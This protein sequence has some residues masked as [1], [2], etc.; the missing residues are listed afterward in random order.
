MHAALW[1][2]QRLPGLT[3]QLEF[4]AANNRAY[5]S[6]WYTMILL[7]QAECCRLPPSLLLQCFFNYHHHHHHH[8]H[9]HVHVHKGV[10]VF[11][12]PWSSKWN[13]SLH[14]FL[15][16]PM[17]LRP[18]GL[19]CNACLG[20]PFVSILC[21]CC[22]H[23]S[24]Y[25]FISFTIFC[26]PVFSLIQRFFSFNCKRFYFFLYI[27]VGSPLLEFLF[28]SPGSKAVNPLFSFR[29]SLFASVLPPLLNTS[30]PITAVSYDYLHSLSLP[31]SFGPVMEK[32]KWKM[33]KK[34]KWSNSKSWLAQPQ[35]NAVVTIITT[36]PNYCL[37]QCV[38]QI[39]TH[40]RKSKK[41]LGTKTVTPTKHIGGT[42]LNLSLASDNNGRSQWPRCPRRWSTWLACR[43]CGFEFHWRH[44]CLSY[45]SVVF[46]QVE[47]SVSGLITRRQESY[48][49]ANLLDIVFQ[50]VTINFLSTRHTNRM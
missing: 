13:M 15:G 47:V 38:P 21:M 33:R 46:Y 31:Q 22:S 6:W 35:L 16:R 19:Y 43:D 50:H 18:F 42:M 2:R 3:F 5:C 8:H 49:G 7:R 32:Q 20:I 11:P 10:G 24:C 30:Q 28:Y 9:H 12:V 23:F 26:A 37:L 36:N 39:C 48:S 44:G 29:I 27:H 34:E 45:V 14:L 4:S 40:S 1:F 17:F 41:H 25:C